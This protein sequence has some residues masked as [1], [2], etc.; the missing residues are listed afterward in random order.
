MQLT[1]YFYCTEPHNR[2][3][4]NFLK[5]HL[6]KRFLIFKHIFKCSENRTGKKILSL[7]ADKA[8]DKICKNGLF[9]K[10]IKKMD[11]TLLY[12][13]KFNYLKEQL[14]LEKDTLRSFPNSNR[15]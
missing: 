15:C 8:F 4:M 14:K 9:S 12:V 6:F 2:L 13:L 11:Q 3:F 10:L 1:R 7:D 5:S